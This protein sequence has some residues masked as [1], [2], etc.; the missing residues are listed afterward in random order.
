[1]PCF[2]VGYS[3]AKLL[4]ESLRV[5]LVEVSHQQ[6]HVAACLWSAGRLDLMDKPHLAWHLSG[7]TTEL[8]L[9]EPAGRNVRCT[10]IGGTSDISA[11]QLIDRTGQLLGLP[12]PAGKHV[13]ALSA[14]SDSTEFFRVKCNGLEF[15]FSGVE[16]KV[17]QFAQSHNPASVCAYALRSVCNAVLAVSKAAQAAYP[18]LEIVFS[19]GVSSNSMLRTMTAPL[20]PIFSDPKYSTDNAM[21]VAVLA[22]RMTEAGL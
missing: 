20:N 18:G 17:R 2:M 8:L 16:N 19:G 12:F 7:G 9:V 14:Q 15:S 3:H 21:G 13:D 1:M 6:G 22:Y 4:S 11:G 5:P 10:C